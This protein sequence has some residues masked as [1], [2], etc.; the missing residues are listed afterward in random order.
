MIGGLEAWRVVAWRAAVP[1]RLPGCASAM[2]AL[3]EEVRAL[4]PGTAVV[5]CDASRGRPHRCRRFAGETDVELEGE[6]LAIP[7]LRSPRYL[8]QDAPETLDYLRSELAVFPLPSPALA[9]AGLALRVAGALGLWR[10]LAVA[11]SGRVAV[12]RRR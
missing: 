3:Q 2:R 1:F 5:L 12:G 9:A 10:W 8:V 11:V 6:Y 4:P 7:S